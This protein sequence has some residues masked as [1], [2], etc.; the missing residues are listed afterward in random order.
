MRFHA[1]KI[2]IERNNTDAIQL[3]SEAFTYRW[4]LDADSIWHR[5][6]LHTERVL[7]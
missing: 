7:T 2:G 4:G 3:A 6:Q 1:I 5:E